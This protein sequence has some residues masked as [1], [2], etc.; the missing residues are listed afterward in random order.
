VHEFVHYLQHQSGQFTAGTCE[1]FVEREREAYAVQ[2]SFFV[3]HGALPA[4]KP[5]HFS[6]S[7]MDGTLALTS[8]R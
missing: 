1:S 2:Q 7:G 4:I 6:C 3:A 5:H 8:S